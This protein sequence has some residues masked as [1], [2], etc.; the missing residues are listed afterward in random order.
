MEIFKRENVFLRGKKVTIIGKSNIV[1]IPL[2]LLLLK[3]DAT[4]TICH[5]ETLDLI[6]HLECADIIISA[7]G[8]PHMIKKEWL[9][10]GVIAI[11]VGI[12][13]CEHDRND[14]SNSKGYYIVGD[15]DFDNVKKIASK[16][17][18]V[19]NGVGLIT[20]AMLVKNTLKGFNMQNRLIY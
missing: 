3:N 8:Q 13:I 14:D 18:P 20:I 9:K 19:P 6:S 10:E 16:I 2:L 12:N 1:G 7:C 4:V 11:D 15:I 5:I 17:T